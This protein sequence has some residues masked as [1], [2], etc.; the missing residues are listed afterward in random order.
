MNELEIR[1]T[2]KV[3]PANKG[4]NIRI[5]KEVVD[6]LRIGSGDT[7]VIDAVRDGSKRQIVITL[8][9]KEAE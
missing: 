3:T 4:F 1:K 5:P 7:Y 6:A 2:G 8:G 9:R